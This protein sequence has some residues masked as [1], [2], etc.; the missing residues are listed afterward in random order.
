MFKLQDNIKV[1]VERWWSGSLC[2]RIRT[3]GGVFVNTVMN[4]KLA[5]N[6]EHFLTSWET[7]SF[8]R[9]KLHSESNGQAFNPIRPEL[10]PICYLLTLLAHDFLY[11]ETLLP[12]WH[13]EPWQTLEEASGYMRLER[14]NKWPNSMT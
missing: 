2:L 10:N 13:K 9:Q 7:I 1:Y 5:K 6:A 4:T 14:V 8:S 3:I 12:N 11:N